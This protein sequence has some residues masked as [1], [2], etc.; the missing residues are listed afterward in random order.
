MS[1]R[2]ALKQMQHRWM[3][4][5]VS[6]QLK[7]KNNGA[8]VIAVNEKPNIDINSQRLCGVNGTVPSEQ[9]VGVV[10]EVLHDENVS[11]DRDGYPV[12]FIL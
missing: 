7:E 3:M 1:V 10:Q 5:N 9:N 2:N 8:P 11:F 12:N 4:H 6:Q